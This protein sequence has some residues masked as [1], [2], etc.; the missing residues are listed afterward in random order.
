MQ[1]RDE[2]VTVD[3]FKSLPSCTDKET[4][5]SSCILTHCPCSQSS[6]Q[7]LTLS[8]PPSIRPFISKSISVF[9]DF[10][11]NLEKQH[12]TPPIHF[13]ALGRLVENPI[14]ENPP[15]LSTARITAVKSS[16]HPLITIKQS[17]AESY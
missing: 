9:K 2:Y 14:K 7:V 3:S 15:Q 1:S 10:M 16:Y 4:V 8:V 5:S 11:R 12:K 6:N 13:Y 17:A